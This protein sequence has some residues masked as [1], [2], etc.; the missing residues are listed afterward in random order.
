MQGNVYAECTYA[1]LCVIV[2]E[3]YL[4]KVSCLSVPSW[5]GVCEAET[6]DGQSLITTL[7]GPRKDHHL[8]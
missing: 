8:Q 6:E 1:V 4:W 2:T 7:P 5:S 3:W